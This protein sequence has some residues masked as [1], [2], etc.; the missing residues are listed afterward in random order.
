MTAHIYKHPLCKTIFVLSLFFSNSS[1]AQLQPA[2]ADSFLNFIKLNKDRASVYITKN[3]TIIAFLNEYKLMPLAS[4]VKLL[5]AVE[6][7]KQAS[8]DIIDKNSYVALTELDKY[9]LPNT[10]GNAHPSWLEY[11]KKNNH[12]RG[13][14]IKLIDVARGMIMFSSNANAEYLMDLLGLENI[15]SNI[16]LFGI[17]AHTSIYPLAASLLMYQ[18]P[19]NISEDKI[20]KAINKFSDENYS[21]QIYSLHVQLKHDYRFKAAFRPGDLTMKMQKAWSDRLPASTTKDYVHL[22]NILNNRAFLSDSAYR[23]IEEV[24]EFPM[25]S[26]AF[27]SV[28]KHYGVKGG[29]TSFVLTHVI[30]F[31]TKANMNMELAVFFN[32]LSPAEEKRLEGWLD[33]FEAQVI[34]DANFR[35]R[36]RF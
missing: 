2:A 18:N 36:L 12:I 21:K 23:I 6:F 32:N 1:M 22:A 8:T 7:A 10:D 14:S 11:E 16:H 20:I 26:K 5:V 27:Q 9:Y 31:R 17:K 15:K 35:A 28:F 24:I 34:F 33:P 29:N 3:D 4:T 30:Y 13:D 25:E 19:K